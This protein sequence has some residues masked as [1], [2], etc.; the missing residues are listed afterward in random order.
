VGGHELRRR[1]G[2]TY[3]ALA[4]VGAGIAGAYAT[5]LAAAALYGLL[6]D[7][8][9]LAVAAGIAA[10][11]L[12]TALR[13][14]SEVV[15]GLG[16]IGAML[17]PV[18]VIAQGGL[19]PLGTGFAAVVYA[20]SLA[21]GLSLRWRA[22]L[23]AGVAA[24]LP[25]IAAL[26]FEGEYQARSPWRI[27]LLGV[28]FFLL[29]AATGVG[30]QLRLGRVAL[31]PLTTSLIL[32]SGVF[33]VVSAAR[34]FGTTTGQGFALL[35]IAAFFGLAAA[36]FFAPRLTRDLSAL[37]AVAGLTLGAFAFADLLSGQPLGYAWAAEAAGLAWLARRTRELR[38]QVGSAA[39]LVLAL[40]H[41]LAVDAPPDRL[42][43]ASAHPMAGAGTALAL[44]VAAGV[45]AVY[46]RRPPQRFVPSGGLYA[47]LAGFFGFVERRQQALRGAA[48]GVGGVAVTYAAS[49]ATLAA[50]PSF[51]WG[52]VALAGLWNLV[53]LAVLFSGLRNESPQLRGGGLAWLAV[54]NAAVVAVAAGSLTPTARGWAAE[55]RTRLP[56]DAAR[57]SSA[58]AGQLPGDAGELRPLL[59]GDPYPAQGNHRCRRSDRCRAARPRRQLRRHRSR[60]SAARCSAKFELVVQRAR[61][62]ARSCRERE[63]ARR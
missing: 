13:W 17:V 30:Y 11:G 35:A 51:D 12:A 26:V 31:G 22:L 24:S 1:Y 10:L 23:V 39:Y 53:G 37:L 29:Y 14:R 34:L 8:G 3:A 6:P 61:A 50:A 19:S 4:A 55:R 25:Q 62:P 56:A 38:F 36:F 41:V 2:E 45:F 63:A 15:A 47:L 27:L 43:V 44:A 42:F 54:T 59:L 52:Y 5:L 7:Y 33:A 49:L 20:A 28:L 60:A 9:A 57:V 48:L 40:G 58:R 32:G 46:A 16:L 21:V 18:A